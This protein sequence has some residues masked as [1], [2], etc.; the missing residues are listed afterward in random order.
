MQPTISYITSLFS[1]L[2][3][4]RK[5]PLA[6]RDK[7]SCLD[8]IPFDIIQIIREYGREKEPIRALREGQTL[9]SFDHKLL[10]LRSDDALRDALISAKGDITLFDQASIRAVQVIKRY[11]LYLHLDDSEVLQER[12]QLH[13]LMR[14]LTL[15]P[16]NGTRTNIKSL[17]IRYSPVERVASVDVQIFQALAQA[18]TDGHLPEL[19]HLQLLAEC[20]MKFRSE[21]HY[22]DLLARSL[23]FADL[24]SLESLKLA[25]RIYAQCKKLKSLTMTDYWDTFDALQALQT[26]GTLS[27]LSHLSLPQYMKDRTN[28]ESHWSILALGENRFSHL[29]M[30]VIQDINLFLEYAK[31]GYVQKVFNKVTTCALSFKVKLTPRTLSELQIHTYFSKTTDLSIKHS[32]I[33]NDLLTKLNEVMPQLRRLSLEQTPN[34]NEE[35]INFTH[36]KHIQELELCI[37]WLQRDVPI[38]FLRSMVAALPQL[39]NIRKLSIVFG[40]LTANQMD[41]TDRFIEHQ[42]KEFS[43]ILEHFWILPEILIL[44]E[45]SIEIINDKKSRTIAYT[46]KEIRDTYHARISRQHDGA[47]CASPRPAYTRY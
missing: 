29:R 23:V 3:I 45:L 21:T 16:A 7:P 24:E 36:F 43:D 38:V 32:R 46:N 31:M 10:M 1:C 42:E 11:P 6:K 4:C 14:I 9:G 15:N 37:N 39:K 47:A 44:E 41:Q 2:T 12:G 20:R 28:A 26:Q 13:A 35:K 30:P 8:P 5:T 25:P 34:Y 17:S 19:R 40:L 33:T 18:K 27:Q 22:V